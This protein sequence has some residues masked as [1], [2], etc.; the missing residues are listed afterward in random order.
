MFGKFSFHR[1]W[2]MARK[3]FIQMRRDRL[4][5]GMMFGIPLVQLIMFGYAINTDP[6][7]L[8]TVVVMGDTGPVPQAVVQALRYTDYFDIAPAPVTEADAQEMLAAGDAMFVITF[9]PNFTRDLMR[10]QHPQ[11][12]IQADATD[13]V[14][15]GNAVGAV[16]NY[17]QTAAT[18]ELQGPFTPVAGPAPPVDFRLHLMYNPERRSQVNI[19]PALLGIVLTMTMVNITAMA[20]VREKERGT[21]E[22]LLSTPARPAEVMLG[23]ILP[24]IAVGYVQAVVILGA[25]RFL[26][27]VPAVGSYALLGAC[28]LLFIMANLGMG[29]LFSTL[30]QSQLQAMQMAFFFFLPSMLLSG[31]FFP[32]RGMPQWA[33]VLGSILPLS[34]FLRIVRGIVLKGNTM[35]E[36]WP[37]L[38]PMGLFF[39]VVMSLAVMRFRRTLD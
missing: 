16:Q 8:P 29:I 9:P 32:F 36:V 14:A 6:K 35:L 18:R 30:A 7:H 1:F 11:L 5:F 22:N 34:H 23:K 2:A 19:V 3:E 10:N 12:L 13:P 31:F 28:M 15:V 33:Q 38:W 24:Y 26:F 25:A 17:V 4:T 27:D 39:L 20:I 21:M 37:Q